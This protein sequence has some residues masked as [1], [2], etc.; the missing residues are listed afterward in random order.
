LEYLIAVLAGGIFLPVV[1][2]IKLSFLPGTK[3]T[4]ATLKYSLNLIRKTRIS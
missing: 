2:K 1:T 4:L 3:G